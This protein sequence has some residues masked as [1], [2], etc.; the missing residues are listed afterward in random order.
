MTRCKCLLLTLFFLLPQLTQAGWQDYVNDLKD[1]VKEKTAGTQGASLTDDAIIEGL[2]QAL[3]QGVEGSVKQ[4]AQKNAFLKDPSIKITMPKALKKV[5][6]GLRK[7]GQQKLADAFISSLNNAAEEAVPGTVD[8]LLQAVKAMTVKDAAGIL[9]GETD[10][11]TQYFK[12]NSSPRLRI[13]IKPVVHKA[14]NSVGVTE[15]YKAM[16]GKAGFVAKYL[17]KDSLD[18]DQYITDKAIDGLFI[19]IALEEKRIR[20]DPLARTTDILKQVFAN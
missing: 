16:I 12:H 7:I 18:I 13:A 15:A 17:D 3:S 1:A 2:K 10:A 6:K 9:K 5:D 20:K 4:L 19:K 11:A 14:T 8:I